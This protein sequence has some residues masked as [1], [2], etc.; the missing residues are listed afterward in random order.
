[1]RRNLVMGLA[2]V[3]L[4]AIWTF[5]LVDDILDV[6]KSS[7]GVEIVRSE[8]RTWVMTL[9]TGLLGS[10][11]ALLTAANDPTSEGRLGSLPRVVGFNGEKLAP[12]IAFIYALVYVVGIMVGL[13]VVL[14]RSTES[15]E[16]LLAVSSGGLGTIA[17]GVAA[18]MNL[19]FSPTPPP[20]G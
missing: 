5:L 14:T 13:V 10:A 4:L 2:A 16:L 6:L 9:L 18:W 20:G 7:S 12:A 11:L 3:G 1:M 19:S 15:S 8:L 17:T